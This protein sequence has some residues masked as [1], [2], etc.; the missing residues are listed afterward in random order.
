MR[1][2]G[3][4]GAALNKFGHAIRAWSQLMPMLKAQVRSEATIQDVSMGISW[5][6]AVGMT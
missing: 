3:F 4:G 5:N 2:Q 6:H 1:R